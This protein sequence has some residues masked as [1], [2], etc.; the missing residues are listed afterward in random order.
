MKKG[1]LGIDV[2]DGIDDKG[3]LLAIAG[4]RT[5]LSGSGRSAEKFI[6]AVIL[7]PWDNLL[8]SPLKA[9]DLGNTN[10][11]QGSDSMTIQ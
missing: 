5:E 7:R 11:G 1:D 2:V 4:P 3:W 9:V 10:I 8:Q 6:S